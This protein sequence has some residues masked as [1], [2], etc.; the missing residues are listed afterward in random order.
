MKNSWGENWGE[1]GYFRTT[2]GRAGTCLGIGTWAD[3]CNADYEDST[4][5][6][7]RQPAPRE[8]YPTFESRDCDT[9]AEY[10]SAKSRKAVA[11]VAFAVATNRFRAA[12]A[13]V[14]S[15][16]EIR[17]EMDALRKA[18]LRY[19][20]LAHTWA[21][22]CRPNKCKLDKKKCYQKYSS[23]WTRAFRWICDWKYRFCKKSASNHTRTGPI[24]RKAS[25]QDYVE[26]FCHRQSA[27]GVTTMEGCEMIA[28]QFIPEIMWNEVR[29]LQMSADDS[30][31]SES[32]FSSED[33]RV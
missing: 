1:N 14:G 9:Q 25:V 18:Y 19:E 13:T 29:R 2:R 4:P 17:Q 6:I 21:K 27:R 7:E 22:S 15:V 23:F 12:G 31:E 28:K 24:E 5:F 10:S 11:H 32:D 30:D 20:A 33:V 8:N 26:N 3:S 16:E